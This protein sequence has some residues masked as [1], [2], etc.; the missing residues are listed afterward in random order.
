MRIFIILFFFT[1][2]FAKEVLI[3]A[4]A[5]VSYALNDIVKEFKKENPNSNIKVILANSGQLTAQI[6]N[7]APFDIFLS[8]DL[9]Y[10]KFLYKKGFAL[11]KPV[12]YAK[13]AIVF[14]S[15]KHKLSSLNDISKLN[16]VALPNPKLA[17][18]GLASVEFLNNSKIK[19]KKIIYTQTITQALSYAITATDGAFVAKSAIKS[20]KLNMKKSVLEIPQKFYNPIKQGM[21]LLKNGKNNI[22]AY[23]FYIF[24]LSKQAQEILKRY[25]YIVE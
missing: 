13:G 6:Q 24:M 4:A 11:T 12:V 23:K 5:N 14:V 15:F 16:K 1:S 3:A 8:A 10:P 20:P 7:N 18:Y 19:P 17:P 22:D 2:L 21:V 25:G 9:K